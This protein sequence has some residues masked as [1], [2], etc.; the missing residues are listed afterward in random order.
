MSHWK[1]KLQKLISALFSEPQSQRQAVRRRRLWRAVILRAA[2]LLVLI[3]MLVLAVTG[4]KA[5]S[6]HRQ[7]K[8]AKEA[9]LREAKANSGNMTIGFT[10]CM[11]LH[12]PILDRYKSEDGTYNFT[13]P[14]Q[15]IQEYYEKPDI[16]ACEMEGT[17]SDETVGYL[18]H[19]LFRY[20]AVFADNLWEVGFDL[21]L[22]ATN[23]IYDGMATGLQTTLD[24]YENSDSAYTGIRTDSEKKR[25]TMVES[26]PIKIGIADYTYGTP[27]QFNAIQ[28]DAADAELINM[29]D[30]A[31]PEEF[32][33]EAQEQIAEMKEEGA[34]MIFFCLHWGAEY[35]MEPSEDQTAIAQQLCDMGVDAIIGGHPHV[36]QPID[37]LQ[38][39]DG[40]H[41]MFCIYSVGNAFS[42][43]REGNAMNSP[44]CEDGL[45]LTFKL[46]KDLKGKMSF[47]EIGLTPT[48]VWRGEYRGE[49][50]EQFGYSDTDEDSDQEGDADADED[51]GQDGGTDAGE[52]AGQ[53]DDEDGD[54]AGQ[55]TGQQ[56]ESPGNTGAGKKY[57]YA[58][59]PLDQIDKL[60][61]LTGIK[62]V[63]ENAKA[64]FERTMEIV[65]AGLEKARR[66]LVKK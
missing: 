7:E 64:S 33:A 36:E 35:Q 3:A 16:M 15:Y 11:I 57:D 29:F 30:E 63:E 20:P 48:W 65:G 24:T 25:W 23:H 60:E 21:Q 66:E 59:L 61:E 54:A 10:G 45:I 2:V 5:C 39:T 52:N 49:E 1:N 58:I 41:K 18:G 46:H 62:G 9:A 12:Q 22:L 44:H 50:S 14:Y 31:N 17:I 6:R 38:S 43:Q 26:G 47:K 40:S 56:E 4:V 8:A 27:Q 34:D 28:V 19:P 13:E 51:S 42:N 55:G 37:V 53:D 32:Y